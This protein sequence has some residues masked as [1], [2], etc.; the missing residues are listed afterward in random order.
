MSFSCIKINHQQAKQP[1]AGEG[2]TLHLPGIGQTIDV[3]NIN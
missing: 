1:F 3:E 2:I